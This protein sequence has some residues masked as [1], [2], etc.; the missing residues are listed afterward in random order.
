MRVL[1][2]LTFIPVFCL[3]STFKI[4]TQNVWM[5]PTQGKDSKERA[6]IIGKEI[7]K[8]DFVAIQEAFTKKS[9]KRILKNVNS[10]YENRYTPTRTRVL[11]SGLF[12]LSRNKIVKSYFTRFKSCAG[13]LC[14]SAKGISYNLIKNQNDRYLQ[15]INIHLQPYYSGRSIRNEQLSELKIFINNN[16]DSRYPVII[17][18]DLNIVAGN[19]ESDD[20][21]A[22]F[23]EFID[24]WSQLRPNDSGYT[25]SSENGYGER[26][27]N[28]RIDY[29]L[30][31]NGTKQHITPTDINLVGTT[32]H[33]QKNQSCYYISDHFGVEATFNIE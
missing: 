5:I 12:E 29:I 27:V 16:I 6:Y 18:G 17:L 20:F 8:Y 33:C 1:T 11:N 15:I 26:S 3:S 10:S 13:I 32:P 9:R 28:E 31:K 24:L 23:P 30:Y 22:K 19:E 14:F 7:N 4:W 2:L 25:L 21:K